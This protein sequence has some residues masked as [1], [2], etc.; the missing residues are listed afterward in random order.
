MK[1]IRFFRCHFG[2][3]FEIFEYKSADADWPKPQPRNSDIG[4]HHL[5][6]YVDDLDAAIAYL[7]ENNIR[8]L[9][10]PT[11]SSN[12]SLGQTWV[13][14]LS[15]W[16]MQFE[17]CTYPDGKAYEKDAKVKLWHPAHPAE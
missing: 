3:N 12:A 14:F 7:K 15:P 1:E 10:E 5:C 13:Y 9:G 11:K 6:F 17:L 16:G 2:S 8:V 4:G